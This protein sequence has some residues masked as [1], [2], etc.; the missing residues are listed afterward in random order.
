MQRFLLWSGI[1][2]WRAEAALVELTGDGIRAGGTQLG[3]DPVP[4][5]LDYELEAHEQFV[6]RALRVSAQGK[7]WARRIDLRHDGRGAWSCEAE[8]EGEVDLPAPGGDTDALAGALDCDLGRSPLT[9]LMPVRRHSLH[10][11]PGK[12][13][14]LMAWVSVPDL[15]LHR[16]PQRYEH[17]RADRHGSIVRFVD[18]GHSP[19]FVSELELDGDGLILVYPHL[20]RRIGS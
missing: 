1:D 16:Y 17:V 6:T 12:L 8:A 2:A 7:G 19:G 20:A 3:V 18:R 15:V 4:Y 13:D 9:N 14:F 5:R 11:Q 10:K